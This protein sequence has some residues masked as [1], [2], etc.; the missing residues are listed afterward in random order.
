M[1]KISNTHQ[2]QAPIIILV[3]PQLAENMGMVARAMM[4]CSLSEL[5]LVKPRDNPLD[6]K[7]IASASGAQ[8]ILEDAKI[9]ESLDEAVADLNIVYA[10]TARRRDMVK[11]IYAPPQPLEAQ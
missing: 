8:S 5:R 9:Y 10:T 6:A 7:A 3:R 1:K 11:P 2:E 4:N